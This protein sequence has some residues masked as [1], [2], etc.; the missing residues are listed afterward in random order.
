MTTITIPLSVLIEASAA[1]KAVVNSESSHSVSISL[2]TQ[3]LF[4][5]SALAWRIDMLVT[6][7]AAVEVTS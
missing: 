7:L 2:R 1:L 5:Q 4:A 6:A 3:C